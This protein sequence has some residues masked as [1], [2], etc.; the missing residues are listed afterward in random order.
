MKQQAQVHL[1]EEQR[2]VHFWAISFKDNNPHL[3]RQLTR[4]V[5]E[6]GFNWLPF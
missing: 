1:T 2:C 6:T 5:V 3:V 4:W